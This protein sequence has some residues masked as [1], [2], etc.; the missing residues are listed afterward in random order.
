MNIL[1][2]VIALLTFIFLVHP[3]T[4]YV[5]NDAVDCMAGVITMLSLYLAFTI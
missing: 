2:L 3:K 5:S 1:F 4:T